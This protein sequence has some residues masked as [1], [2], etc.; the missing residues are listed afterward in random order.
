LEALSKGANEIGMSVE[1]MI[2]LLG[3]PLDIY[4]NETTHWKCV[5]SAVWEY[6]IGGYQIIK[7][8][9]SYR[10]VSVMDRPLSKEEAR[11]VTSMVRRIAAIIL[12]TDTLNSNYIASRDNNYTWPTEN[13]AR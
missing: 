7:K 5:P 13:D 10:D 12:M 9:L 6:V 1:R 2:E 3:S 11:E 4:L 8:W